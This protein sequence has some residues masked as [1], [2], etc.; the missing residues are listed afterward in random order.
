MSRAT[1]RGT[2]R[3]ISVASRRTFGNIKKL[4]SGRYLARY[5][6]PDG[7]QYSG[8]TPSGKS[9]TFTTKGDASAYLARIQTAISRG[10]WVS[11][12][13]PQPELPM[14]FEAY[15]VAWLAER[16]LQTRTREL[17]AGYLKNRIL[18]TFGALHVAAITPAAVRTWHAAAGSEHPRARAGAYALLK[19]ICATAVADD[20]IDANPCRI[21]GAGQA[22]AAKKIRPAALD[23]LTVILDQL[24]E[25]YRVSAMLACWCSLRFGEPA[26]LQRK[27][28]DLVAGVLHVRRAVVRTTAGPEVKSP[29]SAAGIRTVP[30]PRHVLE[31]LA[32]HL[33]VFAQA[34]PDGL[35]FPAA[36]GGLATFGTAASRAR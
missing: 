22:K 28:V 15:A 10:T 29:K 16:D 32:Q 6:G 9:L 30:I 20:V 18:P 35:V 4:P 21:T 23:E 25:R 1:S 11:P 33:D 31:P 36:Q 3:S 24:P 19:S 8:K 17:Y 14:T 2:A 34:G 13:A 7:V 27:D 5:W 26:G 12:D